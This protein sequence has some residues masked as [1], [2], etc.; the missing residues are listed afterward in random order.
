MSEYGNEAAYGRNGGKKG[1]QG[2]D[3]KEGNVRGGEQGERL[4]KIVARGTDDDGHGRNEGILGGDFPAHAENHAAHERGGGTGKAGPQGEALKAAYAEGLKGGELIQI[5]HGHIVLF[6]GKKMFHHKHEQGAAHEGGRH[7]GG[8]EEGF[9]EAVQGQPQRGAGQGG[10]HEHE[11]AA[12]AGKGL[13][14]AAGAEQADEAAPVQNDDGQNGAHLNDHL[15]RG[16]SGPG[17]TQK[18]GGKHEMTG[19]G[20]GK[21]LGKPFHKAEQARSEEGIHISVSLWFRW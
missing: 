18:S 7:G 2:A 4:Q 16:G 15:E 5:L 17:E 20:N 21:K 19:G 1:A 14:V 6:R 10:E 8:S 11:N 13:F 9:D 12:H 3:D